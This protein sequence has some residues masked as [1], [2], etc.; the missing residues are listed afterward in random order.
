MA[1][2][3][4]VKRKHQEKRRKRVRGKISGSAERPRLT[5][6]KTINH[7]YAQLIDDR[8]GVTL[9]HVGSVGKE[10]SAKISSAA[11]KTEQAK[12]IGKMIAELAAEKGVKSVVFDRNRSVYH[13][14]VKALADGAREGGL[15]F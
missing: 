7:I 9:A 3:S 4:K 8:A 2:V 10:V 11:N 1:N 12:L 13:G 14:R 5:V 6:C 15:K